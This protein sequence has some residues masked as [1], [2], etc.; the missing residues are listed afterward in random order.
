M[1]NLRKISLL[2]ILSFTFPA[3]SLSASHAQSYSPGSTIVTCT[4]PV[5]KTEKLLKVGLSSCRYGQLSAT[6]HLQQSDTDSHD[7]SGYATLRICT[8]KR[9]FDYRL[10]KQRCARYQQSTDYWRAKELP[11][12]PKIQDSFAIDS[13][14]IAITLSD[15]Q[16]S[17]SPIGFYLVKNLTSGEITSITPGLL[18]MLYING[19]QAETSYKF[20]ITA[21]NVDGLSTTST[22][23]PTLKTLVRVVPVYVAPPQATFSGSPSVGIPFVA[24]IGSWPSNAILSYQWQSS[25]DG[26]SGWRDISAA[27]TTSYTPILANVGSYLRLREFDSQSQRVSFSAPS[28]TVGSFISN[29]DFTIEMW[30]KPTAG[31]TDRQRQELFSYAFDSWPYSGGHRFDIV[32][33]DTDSS[34]GYWDIYTDEFGWLSFSTVEAVEGNWYHIAVTRKDGVLHAFLNGVE[35]PT[36]PN[37]TVALSPK[38]PINVGSI[39][40]GA[41]IYWGCS[42]DQNFNAHALL[43]DMRVINGTDI[44]L[45]DFTPSITPP[46]N[47]SGT[48]FLLSELISTPSTLV[49]GPDSF[50]QFYPGNSPGLSARGAVPQTSA[51]RPGG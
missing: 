24:N 43:A 37:Y 35:G 20:S 10:I 25:A 13:D 45:S 44:Y 28:N 8:S 47:V 41:D 18:N 26:S 17:D 9:G 1:K 50:Y 39:C 12:T 46:T 30:V 23:T 40:I 29:G 5:A 16:P 14:S 3:L 38:P 48:T 36:H 31:F 22:Q 32:Y 51:E 2:L 11:V 7:G 34:D 42:S 49:L 4:D 15:T 19:L 21:V 33:G 6:W 27:S